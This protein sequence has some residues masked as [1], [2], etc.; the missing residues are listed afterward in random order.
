MGP[1]LLD[2]AGEPQ[3]DGGGGQIVEQ[4]GSPSGFAQGDMQG[5]PGPLQTQ[6][7]LAVPLWA[8]QYFAEGIDEPH[9]RLPTQPKVVVGWGGIGEETAPHFLEVGEGI[10][11]E[12]V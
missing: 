12:Q 5:Q 8:V 7:E 6:E 3:G 1:R 10:R 4:G 9:F 2:R 11:G